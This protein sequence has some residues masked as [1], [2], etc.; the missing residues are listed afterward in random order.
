[1]LARLDEPLGVVPAQAL[2]VAPNKHTTSHLG[3]VPVH[4][5][6]GLM[7]AATSDL[8]RVQIHMMPTANWQGKHAPSKTPHD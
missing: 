7:P 1:M 2:N 3:S 6:I 5:R 4:D 8:E